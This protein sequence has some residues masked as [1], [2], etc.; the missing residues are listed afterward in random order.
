MPPRAR[1]ALAAAAMLLAACGPADGGTRA[2]A[3][4]VAVVGASV[5][6]EVAVALDG[7]LAGTDVTV[8]DRTDHGVISFTNIALIDWRTRFGDIVTT[9]DPDIVVAQV[10]FAAP[11]TG[12]CEADVAGGGILIDGEV[13]VGDA[14]GSENL[15]DADCVAQRSEFFDATLT[16]M[17]D[18]LAAGGAHVLWV[19]QPPVDPNVAGVLQAVALDDA[20][21]ALA[22]L[23]H[24]DATVVDVRAAL[25]ADHVEF[26]GDGQRYRA[27]DGVHLCPPAAVD[28]TDQLVAAIDAAVG[29]VSAGP[30]WPDGEWRTNDRY[31]DCA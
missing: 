17:T 31:A 23:E 12:A 14:G 24:P 6:A 3:P 10:P 15:F 7:A 22:R 11:T 26:T 4:T 1:Y 30:A 9:D 8:L 21:D 2:D 18:M 25:G 28:V 13:Q 19:T 5:A 20:Y 29:D 27:P 16:E